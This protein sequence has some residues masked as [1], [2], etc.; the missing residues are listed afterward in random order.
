ML[1]TALRTERWWNLCHSVGIRLAN[2][3]LCTDD[4]SGDNVDIDATDVR[5]YCYGYGDGD[6]ADLYVHE[7]RLLR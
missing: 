2:S 6:V 3:T 5:R 4:L 1:L 7:P